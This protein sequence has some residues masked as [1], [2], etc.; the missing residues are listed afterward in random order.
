MHKKGK[1]QYRTRMRCACW[2][3]ENGTEKCS[4]DAGGPFQHDFGYPFIIGTAAASLAT[5]FLRCPVPT[6]PAYP[7]VVQ[8]STAFRC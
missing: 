2:M 8:R 4:K 5:C 7:A 1:P 6:S 3:L